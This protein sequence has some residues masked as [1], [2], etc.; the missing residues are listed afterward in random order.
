MSEVRLQT[1]LLLRDSL[2]N[3]FQIQ[4]DMLSAVFLG[5]LLF[6]ELIGVKGK[7]NQI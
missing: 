4:K 2:L 5:V 6:D 1:I 3:E 7:K